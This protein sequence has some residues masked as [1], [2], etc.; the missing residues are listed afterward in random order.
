MENYFS[1]SPSGFTLLELLV[2]LVI[3]SVLSAYAIP[4]FSESVQRYRASAEIS[5]LGTDLQLA[6]SE[7]V[8]RGLSVKVC[9]SSNGTTCTS[10]SGWQ[11]G[12]I[13]YPVVSSTSTTIVPI[14]YQKAWT[15]NDTLISNNS[16]DYSVTF[17]RDG[18]AT[19]QS[20]TSAGTAIFKVQ[21][22]SVSRCLELNKAGRQVIGSCA[23]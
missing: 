10:A 6:R 9:P 5:A 4:A 23:S 11:I 14:R 2:V 19:V 17:T 22:A 1:K 8:K 7:A 20:P 3:I 13:V 16:S 18:F 15:N 12:W 21:T